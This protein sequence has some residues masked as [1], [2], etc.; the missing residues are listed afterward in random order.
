MYSIR[1]KFI[2]G[3]LILFFILSMLPAMHFGNMAVWDISLL[4]CIN[5]GRNVATDGFFKIITDSAAPVAILIP[6][7]LFLKDKRIAVYST[8]TFLCT[9][10]IDTVIK[11]VVN[12]PRPFV[13]YSFIQKVTSGGS[14]SFPS[15]HTTDAFVTAAAISLI[16]RKWY[17]VVPVYIWAL[18]VAWSRMDLGVHYPS[19]VLAGVSLGTMMAFIGYG[20]YVKRGQVLI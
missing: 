12:K 15:G 10:V 16:S 5:N 20:Y 7:L 6:L 9:V 4:K 19:D 13:T 8:L 17:V 14:A 3:I 18:L 11:Y 1:D 2:I